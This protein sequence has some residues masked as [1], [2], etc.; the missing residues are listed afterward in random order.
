M[1][2][3]QLRFQRLMQQVL[4]HPQRKQP[5]ALQLELA[6]KLRQCPAHAT[7]ISRR[8]PTTSESDEPMP[9]SSTLS[10]ATITA[11]VN[12]TIYALTGFQPVSSLLEYEPDAIPDVLLVHSNLL[13]E[14]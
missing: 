9:V 7:L 12:G 6:V 14:L 4:S 5:D 3:P 10:D 1:L 11:V 13:I 8:I 2:Q